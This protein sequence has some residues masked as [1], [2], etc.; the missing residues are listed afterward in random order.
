MPLRA[1]AGSRHALLEAIGGHIDEAEP[2][3]AEERFCRMARSGGLVMYGIHF[4]TGEAFESHDVSDIS[5][6]RHLYER[7]GAMNAE[8]ADFAGEIDRLENVAAWY[9]NVS[10]RDFYI[11]GWRRAGFYPDFVLKARS[12]RVAAI[13]YKG[14]HLLSSPDTLYKERLGRAWARLAGDGHEF[15]MAGRGTAGAVLDGI[16]GM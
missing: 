16:A 4:K 11:Q 9:R 3:L 1:L 12:G 8:E 6:Q 2:A 15:F 5:F 14:A 10:G 7:A 13:E